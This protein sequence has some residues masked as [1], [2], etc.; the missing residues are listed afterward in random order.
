MDSRALCLSLIREYLFRKNLIGVLDKL[1]VET[2]F[3]ENGEQPMST[4]SLIQTLNLAGVHQRNR[5]N[6]KLL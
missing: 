2:G 3:G 5:A 6:G 4:L 1:D